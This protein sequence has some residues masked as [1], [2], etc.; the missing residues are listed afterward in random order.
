[1]KNWKLKQRICDVYRSQS[2]F[3]EVAKINEALVSRIING[4]RKLSDA[5]QAR[6]AGLL[7]CQIKDVFEEVQP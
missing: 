7:N 3:S 4:R 5:E 6:W 1:M 2:D